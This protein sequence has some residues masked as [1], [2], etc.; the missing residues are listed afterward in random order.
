MQ[1]IL[2]HN[3]G[4]CCQLSGGII[5][6]SANIIATVLLLQSIISDLHYHSL[7]GIIPLAAKLY[8][9]VY[10]IEFYRLGSW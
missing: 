8:A 4:S 2:S 3:L 10:P 7:G 1:P 9:T 5:L 6:L